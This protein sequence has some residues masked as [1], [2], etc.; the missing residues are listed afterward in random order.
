MV[1][2]M[3]PLKWLRVYAV[4]CTSVNR[5]QKR[6]EQV[7][8]D[9]VAAIDVDMRSIFCTR[10]SRRETRRRAGEDLD[11]DDVPSPLISRRHSRRRAGTRRSEPM[12][13]AADGV[14]RPKTVQPSAA[15]SGSR[16]R[17]EGGH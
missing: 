15:P 5:G 17:R 13:A 2:K 16:Q 7:K 3:D 1:R 10:S 9:D 14:A 4:P 12:A 6:R 8:C 11:Q